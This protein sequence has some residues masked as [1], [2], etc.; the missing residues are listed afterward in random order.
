LAGDALRRKEVNYYISKSGAIFVGPSAG[1]G[2]A[3]SL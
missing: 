1:S 2:Q 3:E